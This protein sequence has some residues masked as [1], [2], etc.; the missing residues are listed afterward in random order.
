[1]TGHNHSMIPTNVHQPRVMSLSSSGGHL[2]IGDRKPGANF[3]DLAQ[4][5]PPPPAQRPSGKSVLAHRR[6][7]KRRLAAVL[8]RSR[9][10]RFV[11]SCAWER[12][13]P[14]SAQ[15]PRRHRSR[16]LRLR[17]QDAGEQLNGSEVAATGGSG[18]TTYVATVMPSAP[19]TM[20]AA[21]SG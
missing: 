12:M 16:N 17:Y 2:G 9:R 6:P 1:M 10:D 8:T 21:S 4:W 11:M 15:L 14:A 5:D 13:T 19:G 18:G 7:V 20:R 3:D